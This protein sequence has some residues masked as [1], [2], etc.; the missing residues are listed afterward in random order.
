MK[1]EFIFPVIG[2][3]TIKSQFS[4]TN[5]DIPVYVGEN[6]YKNDVNFNIEMSSEDKII[7]T[8]VNEFNFNCTTSSRKRYFSY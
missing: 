3:F 1:R 4:L 7:T 6:S 8:D 5:L 2:I